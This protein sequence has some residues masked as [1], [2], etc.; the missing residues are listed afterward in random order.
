MSSLL[1]LRRAAHRVARNGET[2]WELV[3]A[4]AVPDQPPAGTALTRRSPHGATHV[5][6]LSAVSTPEHDLLPRMLRELI[7][8]LRRTDTSLVSIRGGRAE[9]DAALLAEDFRP[10]GDNLFLLHL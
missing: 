8:A 3:D 6:S 1:V 2:W 5:V 9:V 10:A 4:A 7:A